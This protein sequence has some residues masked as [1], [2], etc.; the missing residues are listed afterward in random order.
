[1][2]QTKKVV[3]VAKEGCIEDLKRLLTD[4]VKPSRAEKGS[5]LYHIYQM[6]EKPDTF[7]VIETWENEEALEGHRNSSHYKY[8][9]SH[10]EQF[11]AEKYSDELIE[12]GE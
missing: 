11:T 2:A 3:F 6:K 10:F 5:L 9:K 1:M 12:L 7:V 4:M 8:Y